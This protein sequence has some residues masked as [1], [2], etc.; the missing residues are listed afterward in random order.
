MSTFSIANKSI[1]GDDTFLIAEVGLSHEGSLGTARAYV[2]ALVGTGVDAV[3]FQTHIADAEGTAREQFRV[4]VFPQDA[5]RSDYWRRTAFTRQQ[6][7]DLANYT[8][9]RG[10]IFMSSPFSELAV[11]YLMECE[12]PAWK[13]ASGEITNIPL[14]ELIA[15]T[16]RPII[17]SSGMSTLCDLDA[18]VDC[19]RS[20]GVDF[21][22]LQCTSQYPCPPQTWGLNLI[23]EFR[24]RWNCPSGLS[25]HSGTIAP[26]IAATA[27]GASILEIHVT[28]HRA[29][30]GPDVS[31]SLTL[32]EVQQLSESVQK[33]NHALRHPVQKST[34]AG[35]QASMQEL[36]T[37][38]IVAAEEL[39]VGT[40]LERHHFA[41][42]KP[43]DG[44]P[45]KDYRSLIGCRCTRPMVKDEQF[46]RTCF[47]SES[48]ANVAT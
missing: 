23:T 29:M 20:R 34:A 22:V 27:L 24:D 2:D 11:E 21:A 5:T 42:K 40:V 8:R 41:F 6:W 39:P 4:N 33:L 38:S 1:G 13:I 32:N 15:E 44:I 35:H 48:T 45:A 47:E 30:F 9:D 10:L 46:D 36:F 3:K 31:S 16:G 43:G 25:D 28:F 26:S 37:K 17:L 7:L 19:V 14:L 18:A 12:V